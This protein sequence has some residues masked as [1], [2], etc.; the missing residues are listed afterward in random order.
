MLLLIYF[1]QADHLSQYRRQQLQVLKLTGLLRSGDLGQ[2]IRRA[3]YCLS[4]EACHVAVE[5][6]VLSV[7]ME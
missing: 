5:P 2:N 4:A 3:G 6:V 1:T 7:A